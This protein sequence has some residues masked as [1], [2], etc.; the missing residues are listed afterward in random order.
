MA[1]INTKLDRL[2]YLFDRDSLR[3]P[4]IE[5]L[6]F[7]EG[8]RELPLKSVEEINV[9][10]TKL[11]DDQFYSKMVNIIDQIKFKKIISIY[12]FSCSRWLLFTLVMENRT[13]KVLDT[14]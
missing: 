6:L 10:E 11:E 5:G 7:E 8:N 14:A 1:K 13:E 3:Q 9:F 2:L 12:I 4:F